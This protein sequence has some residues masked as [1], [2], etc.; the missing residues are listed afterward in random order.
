M[1][2]SLF[3]VVP[4]RLYQLC[5]SM[6]VTFTNSL[7][8]VTYKDNTM[9]QMAVKV[10]DTVSGQ[11]LSLLLRLVIIIL[12]GY[13]V[14]KVFLSCLKRGGLLVIQIAVGALY[15]FSVPRGYMDGFI[16]W[17][18]QVIGICFTSFLQATMLIA[19]LM[20]VQDH[21]LLGVGIMFASSEIPR[22]AQQFG[23]DT[24]A[25]ANFSSSV[26]AIQSGVSTIRMLGGR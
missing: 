23:M 12:M 16:S 14:I 1:S 25:R 18:K 26:Y 17:C 3:T 15:M 19:G 10:I 2:V 21:M 4:L 9:G 13:A 8:E 7:A 6:Q 22:I 11:K 20:V 5:T 24:S